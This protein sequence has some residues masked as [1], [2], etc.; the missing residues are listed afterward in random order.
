MQQFEVFWATIFCCICFLNYFLFDLDY[1]WRDLLWC[2]TY[3]YLHSL[4]DGLIHCCHLSIH[5]WILHCHLSFLTNSQ[6]KKN[7]QHSQ[8]MIHCFQTWFCCVL[9]VC[10]TCEKEREA[11]KCSLR[12]NCAF[13]IPQLMISIIYLLPVVSCYSV[14]HSAD[15]GSILV[16]CIHIICVCVS[17]TF[18]F[19]TNPILHTLSPSAV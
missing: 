2:S 17:A 16:I 8:T 9:L 19:H 3:R 13:Y 11:L 1:C 14:F 7:Y 10:C 6:N 4:T 18:L 12:K 5:N 15:Y